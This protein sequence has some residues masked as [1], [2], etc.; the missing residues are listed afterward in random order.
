MRLP[1]ARV[2][3]AVLS[4]LLGWSVR[5]SAEPSEIAPGAVASR[6]RA[7][8]VEVSVVRSTPH[9]VGIGTGFFVSHDGQVLTDW[10]VIHDAV[11]ITVRTGRGETL[12]AL[13]L[14]EDRQHDLAVGGNDPP[15]RHRA[16]G[17]L[18]LAFEF[19]RL[20][21]R[22]RAQDAAGFGLGPAA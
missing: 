12:T 17:C 15:F 22:E 2:V 4:V 9:H 5:G 20:E 8:V 19:R 3:F 13:V 11:T 6:A 18:A 21:F 10:H 16:E 14:A 1:R 7:A